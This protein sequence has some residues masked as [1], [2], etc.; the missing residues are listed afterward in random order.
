MIT[1]LG[2]AA[3][4]VQTTQAH[5]LATDLLA[6]PFAGFEEAVPALNSLTVF[7]DPLTAK[8]VAERLRVRL[9]ELATQQPV[10]SAQMSKQHLL[11]IQLNGPDLAW[12]LEHTQ[13]EPAE[14]AEQLSQLE[15]K[16]AFLGFTP[17]FAFLTGLPP[18]LQMPRLA[19]PRQQVAAG[20]AAL[21]GPW[22][23]VYP[24]PTPG[25]WR[26]IGHTEAAL[27]DAK[28][29]QPFLLSAGDTVHFEVQT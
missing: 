11:P 25:G 24:L 6:R 9:V 3:Y 4:L 23:G 14:F 21:G 12:V 2:E 17:G 8:G 18:H 13:L 27:F 1:R 28:R 10:Q 15:L 5:A 26:L 29:P 7:V 20:S 19:T 22:A 16:V